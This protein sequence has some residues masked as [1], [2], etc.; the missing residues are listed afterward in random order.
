MKKV[1]EKRDGAMQVKSADM[2][3]KISDKLARIEKL[4]AIDAKSA[5]YGIQQK[6]REL[7]RRQ[8]LLI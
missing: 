6:V 7:G 1:Q 2:S 3:S 5:A 8:K 4:Q